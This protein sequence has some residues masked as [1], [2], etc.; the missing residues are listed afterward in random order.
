MTLHGP[1]NSKVKMVHAACGNAQYLSI[2][3]LFCLLLPTP[4]NACDWNKLEFDP[5]SI[6]RIGLIGPPGGKRYL[7]Y[8][9]CVPTDPVI[10]QRLQI[11]SPTLR[12][13]PG[14]R[15]RSAC[16]PYQALCIGNTGSA[17]WRTE[18]CQLSTLPLI[19]RIRPTWWE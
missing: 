14:A 17:N 7:D 11:I 13:Q 8:E 16:Q 15:G 12:C 5:G 2:T 1:G 6:D 4:G 3:L 9:F 19:Q 10:L 18:L